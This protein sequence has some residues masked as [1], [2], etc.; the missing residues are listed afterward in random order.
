VAL[1]VPRHAGRWRPLP[2]FV[3]LHGTAGAALLAP[4]RCRQTAQLQLHRKAKC[5]CCHAVRAQVRARG[6]MER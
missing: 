5:I 1:V 4:V 6:A 2:M 3:K